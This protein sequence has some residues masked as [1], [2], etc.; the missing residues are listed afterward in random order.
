LFTLTANKTV[1]WYLKDSPKGHSTKR[2]KWLNKISI[3]GTIKCI[4]LPSR[5]GMDYQPI[6]WRKNPRHW[7][8]SDG[9]STISRTHAGNTLTSSQRAN[10]KN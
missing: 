3:H 2:S 5:K 10:L 8:V 1:T 6:W 4:R 9:R 7:R